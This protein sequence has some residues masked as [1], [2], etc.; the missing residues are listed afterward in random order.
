[1]GPTI[2]CTRMRVPGTRCTKCVPPVRVL[3]RSPTR[4]HRPEPA[5]GGHPKAPAAPGTSPPFARAA[6]PAPPPPPPRPHTH[7]R[8][9][10]PPSHWFQPYSGG[11]KLTAW[12]L[13]SHSAA[14]AASGFPLLS[15]EKS[16]HSIHI[17]YLLRSLPTVLH[18]HLPPAP[19]SGAAQPRR[20]APARN[21]SPPSAYEKGNT[22]KRAA[23]ICVR[24]VRV[25]PPPPRAILVPRKPSTL[26]AAGDLSARGR[27]APFRRPRAPVRQTTWL[28][29]PPFPPPGCA[30]FTSPSPTRARPPPRRHSQTATPFY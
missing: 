5:A 3:V 14:R 8:F 15:P 13:E 21:R 11:A 4:P 16:L 7:T 10:V 27:R 6:A 30:V 28:A 18:R 24:K 25:A 17:P 9:L 22:G 1:M 23:Y 20:T 29:P 19:N 26:C 2:S 12:M